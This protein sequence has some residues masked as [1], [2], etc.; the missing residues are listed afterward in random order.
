MGDQFE[1]NKPICTMFFADEPRV[2]F[3]LSGWVDYMSYCIN[4][5]HSTNY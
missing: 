2:S 3:W 1:T 4:Q 5:L